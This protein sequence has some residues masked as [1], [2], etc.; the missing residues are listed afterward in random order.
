MKR[1]WI[2]RTDALVLVCLL[3]V[4]LVLFLVLRPKTAGDSVSVYVGNT[5]HAEFSLSNA[6]DSY[7]VTTEKGSLVLC[8]EDGAV[9]AES[10]DCPDGVCVRT[11]S[12]S[13]R[14]ESIVCVPLGIC[15]TVEGGMLDGVTG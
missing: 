7:T 9:F 3:A 1:R 15:V 12:I 10:A 14:G 2:T 4:I 6:P 11:G 5:L 8:F 13:K